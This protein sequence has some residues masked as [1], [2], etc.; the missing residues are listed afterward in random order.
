MTLP[1]F[2]GQETDFHAGLRLS[3]SSRITRLA[4]RHWTVRTLVVRRAADRAMLNEHQ[5]SAEASIPGSQVKVSARC[6]L[7][8]VR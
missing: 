8:G 1:R 6:G 2:S 7:L 5:P 3:G 4:P